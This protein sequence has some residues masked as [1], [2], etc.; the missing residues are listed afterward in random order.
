VVNENG[1]EIIALVE[2]IQKQ[3]FLNTANPSYPTNLAKYKNIWK[4]ILETDL[5]E[6]DNDVDAQYQIL[7]EKTTSFYNKRDIKKKSRYEIDL[8]KFMDHLQ[9]L[10]D[11]E[12]CHE[13]FKIKKF[14]EY[15]GVDF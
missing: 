15:F 13:K 11:P 3:S 6:D 12:T 10:D 4:N 7:K 1:K 5:L 9:S 14:K 8:T 2:L